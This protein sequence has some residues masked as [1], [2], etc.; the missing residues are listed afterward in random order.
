MEPRQKRRPA[1]HWLA[2]SARTEASFRS[3]HPSSRPGPVHNGTAL[4]RFPGGWPAHRGTTRVQLTPGS[5]ACSG[6]RAPLRRWDKEQSERRVLAA[7]KTLAN[8]PR[9]ARLA[10]PKRCTERLKMHKT[11]AAAALICIAT[12]NA[13]VAPTRSVA[14][15]SSSHPQPTTPAAMRQQTYACSARIKT[16]RHIS[17][18]AQTPRH[19]RDG[20]STAAAPDSRVNV[21]TGN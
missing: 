3:L 2:N 5:Q 20:N 19:R 8:Q 11:R 12:T 7:C 4:T 17:N 6:T 13:F 16:S 9:A 21:P 15:P 1:A 10:Q 14:R 18:H